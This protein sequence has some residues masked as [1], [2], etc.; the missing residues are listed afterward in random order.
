MQRS[1]A[2]AFLMASL[3]YTECARAQDSAADISIPISTTIA[4]PFA[5]GSTGF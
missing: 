4:V 3:L 5:H 1:I 2:S